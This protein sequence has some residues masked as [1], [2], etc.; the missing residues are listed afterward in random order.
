MSKRVLLKI[1]KGPMEGTEFAFDEHDTFLFGRTDECHAKLPDDGFASRLHFII[2]ANPP[3]ARLRDLG[4]LNGTYV[5]GVL[6][7]GRKRDESP[8]EG[9]KRAHPFV[10]LKE[11]DIIQVGQT[12]FQVSVTGVPEEVETDVVMQCQFCG[13]SV[14]TEVGNRREGRYVCVECRTNSETDPMEM[15]QNILKDTQLLDESAASTISHKDYEVLRVLGKGAMGT[16]YLARHKPSDKE[17][18]L[19]VVFSRVSASEPMLNSFLREMDFMRGLGHENIVSYRG[20][21]AAGGAL[22]FVMEHCAGGSL[23]RYMEEQG[24]T[25]DLAAAIPLMHQTL[26]GLAYAHGLNFVHRDIKPKNVLLVH[27]GKKAIAKICDFGLAKNFE[28]AGLS[29]MTATGAVGGAMHFI[30]REQITDYKHAN[31]ASDV[32]SLG[33]TFY[34]M[35]TGRLPRNFEPGVDALK[36]ILNDP[37][38]PIEKRNNRLPKKLVDVINQSLEPEPKDRFPSAA[39]FQ[40]AL[41][42]MI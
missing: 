6:Y 35:L 16:V 36:V 8:E 2:E 21:G 38:V 10:D 20:S 33:A 18:A 22:Y 7:G 30:P 19:K 34:N 15:L 1:L 42:K 26:Q 9:A 40:E 5:N 39:E 14:K 11:G 24:G 27:E 17:V 13:C 12:I 23:D 29:G 32:W 3:D 4:S 25:L 28:R 31:P 41:E 37:I